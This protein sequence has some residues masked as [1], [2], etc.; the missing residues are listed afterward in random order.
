MFNFK[1]AAVA[2]QILRKKVQ[3]K[4]L[5]TSINYV[6]GCDLTFLNPFKTPTVGIAAFT[7]FKYP[8]LD[9]IEKVWISGEVEIPYVPG[10]LAFREIPLLVRAF[11]KLSTKPDI[12]IV[13]GHGIAHPRRM[14]VASHFGV[15]TG[16]PTIGCA[17]KPLYGNFSPP[18]N[19]KGAFSFIFDEEG[20][21]IGAVLRTKVNV[22][23]V[24]VSPGHLIDVEGGLHLVYNCVKSYRLPEPTR[25]SH[26]FLKGI[27]KQLMKNNKK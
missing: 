19:R 2:Q 12:V 9:L 8:E 16:T 25:I 24:Y 7:L 5:E 21:R 17:K 15:V 22:K 10:F 14:G 18:E 3:V 11:N 1:K 20:K 26:N 27:R 23:P 4:P 13:D 6:A